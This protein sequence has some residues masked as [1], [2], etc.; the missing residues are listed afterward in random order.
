MFVIPENTPKPLKRK[1]A[2][3]KNSE[4]VV[5]LK[6]GLSYSS[7]EQILIDELIFYIQQND[8]KA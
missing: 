8:L 1:Q 7:N 5:M 3:A 6:G 2:I 4:G